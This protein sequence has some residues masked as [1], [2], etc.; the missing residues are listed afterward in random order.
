MN[1]I[2]EDQ[3]NDISKNESYNLNIS[4][5]LENENINIISKNSQNKINSN[6]KNKTTHLFET[7]LGSKLILT[8][9]SNMFIEKPFTILEILSIIRSNVEL[10]VKMEIIEKLKMIISKHYSNSII[11]I[12]KSILKDSKS[13]INIS[14]AFVF[15]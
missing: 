1:E 5:K 2:N 10:E 13:E 4:S 9:N 6:K 7:L 14:K 12:E 11:L 3:F 8:E 15:E